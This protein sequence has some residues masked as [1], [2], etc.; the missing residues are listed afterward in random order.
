MLSTYSVSGMPQVLNR[1]TCE[2]NL[3]KGTAT[4]VLMIL[5]RIDV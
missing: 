4:Y 3:C 1:G 2:I 5:Q